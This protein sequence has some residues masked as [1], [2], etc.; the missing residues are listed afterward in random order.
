MK[1]FPFRF[2]LFSQCLG[3]LTGSL[4]CLWGMQDHCVG[5]YVCACVSSS[6]SLKSFCAHRTA[7]AAEKVNYLSHLWQYNNQT[8]WFKLEIN[9]ISIFS[10][11]FMFSTFAHIWFFL[12]FRRGASLPVRRS[13]FHGSNFVWCLVTRRVLFSSRWQTENSTHSHWTVLRNADERCENEIK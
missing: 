8:V 11:S 7:A 2:E 6:L 12:F 4:A 3:L 1:T 5:V 9:S 13:S 10:L